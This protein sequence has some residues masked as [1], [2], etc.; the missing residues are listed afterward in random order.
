ML[1]HIGR[2]SSLA[3]HVVLEVVWHD[4]DRDA[5]V[6]SSGWGKKSDWHKNVLRQPRV[7]FQIGNRHVKALARPLEGPDARR[8]IQA[9]ASQ[10]AFAFREISL[11][12]AYS[13]EIVH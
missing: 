9:Y 13:D 6:V 2:T 5:H 11:L 1:T 10:H 7:E 12:I 8:A 3:R 4:K